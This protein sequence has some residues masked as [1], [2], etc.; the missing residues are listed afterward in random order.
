MKA[1]DKQDV[2]AEVAHQ[3]SETLD[4]LEDQPGFAQLRKRL[5]KALDEA[6]ALEEKYRQQAIENGQY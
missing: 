4:F 5:E 2:A 6:G 1:I 3:I